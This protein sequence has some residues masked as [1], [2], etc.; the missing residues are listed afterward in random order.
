MNIV[1]FVIG[2]SLFST[3]QTIASLAGFNF[4]LDAIGI[5]L[6]MLPMSIVTLFF[7]PTVGFLVKRIGPKWPM[8]LGM[9]L[10]LVGFAILYQFH[11]TQFEVAVSMAVMGAGAAFAMVGSI[12]MVIVSTPV[13]ETGIS[14][15]INMIVRTSGSV[16]GPAIAAV[17]IAENSRY[18]ASIGAVVPEDVAYQLIFMLAAV[19]AGVGAIISM[20]T[21]E[22][23]KV[24]AEAPKKN[25]PLELDTLTQ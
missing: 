13:E 19:I 2:F 3:N 12:N 24:P 18:D 22:K 16:V 21:E 20:Y 11:Y 14:T 5:G 15:A 8:T 17:I 25:E 23:H 7:G 4:R 1:A 9:V 10:S 6:L